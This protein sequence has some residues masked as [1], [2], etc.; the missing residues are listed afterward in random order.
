MVFCVLVF[1][2]FYFMCACLFIP[3]HQNVIILFATWEFSINKCNEHLTDCKTRTNG[4]YT[5]EYTMYRGNS[6]GSIITWRR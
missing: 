4:L 2:F 5:N 6:L 3:L 1:P